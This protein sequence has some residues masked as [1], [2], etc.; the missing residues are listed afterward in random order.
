MFVYVTGYD[1]PVQKSASPMEHQNTTIVHEWQ[2][3]PPQ[4]Y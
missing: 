1:Q 2:I 4:L 3:K